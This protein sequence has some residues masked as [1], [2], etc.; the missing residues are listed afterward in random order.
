M[1]THTPIGWF[2]PHGTDRIV[3]PLLA[4]NRGDTL[5]TRAV[6]P[7]GDLI[8]NIDELPDDAIELIDGNTVRDLREQLHAAQIRNDT[9]LEPELESVRANRDHIA[10]Q[11]REVRDLG[12][13]LVAEA[14]WV[15]AR[16]W[17]AGIAKGR[18][19]CAT[20][21]QTVDTLQWLLA[22]QKW[23]N[24]QNDQWWVER[25]D[26]RLGEAEAML[27]QERDRHAARIKD[28][29]SALNE[30]IAAQNGQ[31]AIIQQVTRE[32]DQ[33]LA[34][35]PRRTP[36]PEPESWLAWHD[37]ERGRWTV[38][39]HRT[40]GPYLYMSTSFPTCWEAGTYAHLRARGHDHDETI[41]LLT[42]KGNSEF[43]LHHSYFTDP[44]RNVWKNFD[45]HA[46]DPAP[47]MHAG[48]SIGVGPRATS[49]ITGATAHLHLTDQL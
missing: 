20:A 5:P 46:F 1:T 35:Q 7:S 2:L 34:G 32:R 3:C 36:A 31:A 18:N 38:R 47:N 48:F 10:L 37:P 39:K 4:I 8:T 41:Q 29:R 49:H 43:F 17:K 27:H 42:I 15:A 13:W 12:Q 45:S 44:D 21:R 11:F 16:E 25:I 23:I 24:G 19:E 9:Y 22:E 14:R 28:V 40:D 26:N 6:S 30:S 33:A